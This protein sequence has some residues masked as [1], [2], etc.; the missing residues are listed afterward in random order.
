MLNEGAALV[1]GFLHKKSKENT[2][3]CIS[4]YNIILGM[5]NVF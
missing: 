2:N 1:D 5:K 4:T 3:I